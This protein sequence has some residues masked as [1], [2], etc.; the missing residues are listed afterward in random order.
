M[1]GS[2]EKGNQLFSL[3]SFSVSFSVSLPIFL[4]PSFTAAQAQSMAFYMRI[5]V[6]SGPMSPSLPYSDRHA[7]RL[8]LICS[9]THTLTVTQLL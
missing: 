9:P 8:W 1:Y 7:A 4:P 5:W 6:S 3:L 2:A